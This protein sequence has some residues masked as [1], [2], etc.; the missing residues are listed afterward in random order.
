M[1]GQTR[2]LVVDDDTRLRGLLGEYLAGA[3]FD[4]AA[5]KD[6]VEARRR[7]DQESFDLMVVDVMMPGETGLD[8]VRG[9][10]QR[11]N[12][13]PVLMLTALGELEDR[14]IGLEIG[15][16]DY[17]PK[18]F[19]PE[20]LRARIEAVLRRSR[21]PKRKGAA[22]FGPFAFD[23]DTGELRRG[24]RSVGLTSS[25]Q[26]LLAVLAERAGQPV[27]REDLTK[28]LSGISERSID[29]QVARLRRKIEDD[30]R[31]PTWL[32]TARGAG[33]VLKIA[34]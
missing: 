14:V 5:A 4:V 33:Y 27:T 17:L 3:G 19:E 29:V 16:D 10:R 28:H 30:P 8:L 26:K 23:L 15:A 34:R 24:S 20:E 11:H 31:N 21:T 6:A 1:A 2:I 32:Q 12:A 25:E 18:P 13:I 7:L 9:L 22:F